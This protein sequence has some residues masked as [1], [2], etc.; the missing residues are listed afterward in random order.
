MKKRLQSILAFVNKAFV[1]TFRN[2]PWGRVAGAAGKTSKEMGT[3]AFK[4]M[5]QVKLENPVK[6]V[7]MKLFLMF[8]ISILFFVLIVGMISYSVSKSVIKN[9]VAESSLQTVTQAG[10]KLDFLYQTFE[11]TSLQIML[12]K[13]LQDLLEKVPTLDPTSYESLE[14]VRQLTDKLN[15]VTFANK[16]IKTLHLYRPDGKL[17][18]ITGSGGSTLSENSGSTDWF[19]KI[20]DN[21]GKVAWLDSK[22]KGYSSSSTNTFA[23]G[24]LMRNTLTNS[25]TAVLMLELSTD[26]LNKEIT[27]M[28]LGDD[29]KV[30]ITNA[31]NKY[32]ASADLT[33]LEKDAAIQ[34]TKEQRD[35]E[36]G[37]FIT[38][39]DHL[40]AYYKSSLS[41]W[42]LVGDIPVSSLVKDAKKIFNYTLLIALFAAIAAVLIGLFVARMIGRPLINLRNLMQQGAKGKL[43]VRANYTT[44][45][46]IGQLGASFDVMMQQIT[47]LVQ[48]T[49][50]SA[51]AVFETAQELTNSSKVTATAAREIAVATDEIS[52]GAGGLATESERGNELTHHIGI[53]MKQV[54]EANLE[55]GTAAAD[56]Q[57]SSEQGTKYMSELISKTNL[58]E[59]MIRSMVDKVDNLKDSTRSIRKILDVLNNMTKQTNILS[60]NATIEAA[61]AGAAGKGF[62]VVADE[63]RK[64]ADQSRQS[65]DVVGQ[66]TE[67]IQ[68]EID[69]TVKVL[70]TATPIFKEQILAVKEAD[71][72]FKQVTNHMGG[73]IEQLSTVSDSISTLEQSQVVLSDAMTNVSAVAEESLA[74]SEE[75]ASLS[76]EQLSISDGLVK[77]S[78]KLDLLSKSLTDTLSKFEV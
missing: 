54:I 29:S 16:S 60:L 71:I 43:T 33:E 21:G 19:K 1:Q 34:L 30:V 12:N 73:F 49:S 31:E 69:E 27:G 8:F 77:L 17:I 37:S 48:Q 39:D 7:G 25:T 23:I 53:Q 9:K 46:E 57:S 42:N 64:L 76:S 51:Q 50:T 10:Q 22:V 47:T 32:I 20:V 41:G 78:D 35:Q 70:S 62:M 11:D 74:T 18:V 26:L 5:R 24:R 6:S 45:D 58:T 65:I 3:V 75:V 52:N 2:V 38:K 61:R 55:M 59:E 14:V 40:V 36:N 68:K 4:E 63:I 13:E 15:V 56:V 67:T 28:S 44:Q 72:I 66:I